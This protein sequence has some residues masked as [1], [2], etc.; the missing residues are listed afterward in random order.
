MLRDVSAQETR[1]VASLTSLKSTV[2]TSAYV[3]SIPL[4]QERFGVIRE[5]ALLPLS[6][7][8]LG[9]TVGPLVYAPLSEL[10]GR[11]VVY[12]TSLP[13]LLFFTAI[14]GAAN[15]LP[16][17]IIFRLLAGIGGSAPLAV[18]AGIMFQVKC[19]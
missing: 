6:L 12:W 18:G 13:L 15:N 2:G 14:A 10:Y 16:V 3:P 5:V 1:V 4:I 11:R 17:L 19:R 7:Y 9:F 8:T